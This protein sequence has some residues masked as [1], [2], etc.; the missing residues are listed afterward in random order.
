MYE[1]LLVDDEP[2]EREVIRFL[3]KKNAFPFRITEASNGRQAL[4]LLEKQFFHVLFTDIKM[5]F[6]DGLDLA[7]QA[8]ERYPD[9][10]IVFFSG[11][12]DFESARKALSLGVVNYILKPVSPE[13]LQRTFA[14]ILER[15]RASEASRVREQSVK[16]AVRR[17]ALLQLVNGVTPQRLRVMYPQWNFDFLGDY[18]RMMLLRLDGNAAQPDAEV[19]LPWEELQQLLPE[20]CQCVTLKPG[21][22]LILFGGKKHQ[23]R[24]YQD[25]AVQMAGCVRTATGVNCHMEVSHSFQGPEDIH[26]VYSE[27]KKALGDRVFFGTD[28][29]SH[30]AAAPG[31]KADSDDVMLKRLGTDIRLKDAGGLRQ[32][33]AALLDSCRK[34]QPGSIDQVRYVCTKAVTVLLDSL[35][36]D[37]GASFDH[38]S[39]TI[40]ERRFSVIE[41]LLL[42]LTEQV[43]AQLEAGQQSQSHAVV[44]TKQ[45]IHKHYG[46]S[47]SLNTLAEK[48]H[49]S[50]RYLSSLFV[51]E[52]GI[53]INRYL[54]KVRMQKA[55]ELLLGTNMKVSEICVKVGYSNLSYFCK[56]FQDDFGVTPDKFRILPPGTATEGMGSSDDS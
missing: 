12:D 4:D 27:L 23:R 54:K 3:I 30:G 43:A 40:Q 42:D 18:H 55:R 46:E 38:Y 39:R 36:S 14:G 31:P 47:L 56:S 2:V 25:L 6:V 19:F 9:L 33:M 20:E 10:H 35:P 1:I 32:H 53:G 13:E 51:E 22:G 28:G 15:L 29:H 45:Y 52:E 5:P 49:L 8:R 17:S 11:Y 34:K 41:G 44:L 21:T 50:P 16:G 37:S 26:K 7:M 24:W 48:V